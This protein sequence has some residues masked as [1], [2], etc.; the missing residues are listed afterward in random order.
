MSPLIQLNKIIRISKALNNQIPE[1]NNQTYKTI[2]EIEI[3]N[4]KLNLEQLRRS[5]H[6][7]IIHLM[8]IMC[9]T[10]KFRTNSLQDRVLLKIFMPKQNLK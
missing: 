5:N 10:T 2:R 6:K 4:K 1:F 7:I 3:T 9:I 8:V